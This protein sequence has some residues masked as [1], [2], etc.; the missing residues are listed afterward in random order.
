MRE[1][2]RYVLANRPTGRPA[3]SDFDLEPVTVPD[4]DEGEVLVGIE[5]LS[6]DPYLRDMMRE[7]VSYAETWAL[8]D[9]ITSS[10]VGHVVASRHPDVD[11]GDVVRGPVQWAAFDLVHGDDLT[12]VDSDRGPVST[13][14]G[15]LGMAGR[16]AYFGMRDVGDPAPDETVV[17][18]AAAGA[19]GSVACQIA[20]LEG[21]RVVGIAG[22]SRKTTYLTDELGVDAAID[23]TSEDVEAAIRS[24][25]PDGV[26]VY[27]DN[28]GG[29][30]SD[31]VLNCID[32]H[33]RIVVCGQVALYNE[34]GTPT[35]PRPAPI[36]ANRRARM[37]GFLVWDYEDRYDEA[38]ERLARW[39]DE[40]TITYREHVVDGLENAPDAFVGLFDGDNVGKQLVH[41]D[42]D[43]E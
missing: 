2:R 15:V 41:V 9:P 10:G 26:D 24:Q 31:A 22:S 3:P 25:C 20:A 43:G 30:I 32:D 23:Y 39:V 38:D 42:H 28:V 35:G 5:Y 37:E 36:L 16:T 40:G 14:L 13:A 4:P 8:G 7:S 11:V 21:C 33:A 18:S 27:F 12:R 1:T 17:V 19:V 6:V 29:E 34:E